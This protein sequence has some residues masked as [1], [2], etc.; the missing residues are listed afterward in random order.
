MNIYNLKNKKEILEKIKKIFKNKNSIIISGGNTIKHII[1]DYNSKIFCKKILLSDERLVKNY[2]KL[3]NDIFF[4]KLIKRKII[5]S[6][7]LLN[8]KLGILNEKK[9][10]YL[11]HKI[12]KI[13]FTTAILSLGSNGHFASIF[14]TRNEKENFYYI[15]NSPKLPKK[16]VTVAL[17]KISKC[18]K[19]YFIAKRKTKNNEIINFKKNKLLKDIDKKKIYLLTY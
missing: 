13:N 14:N 17:K 4:K 12:S 16:R 9:I 15:N 1:K 8:Y 7:Q 11:S 6:N 19:I 2:S 5:N 18:K 10:R 3:R